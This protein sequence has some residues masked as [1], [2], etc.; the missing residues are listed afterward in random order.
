VKQGGLATQQADAVAE[1]I[2]A[3]AG[4]AVTPQPFRPIL[5]GML[6]TGE[7]PRYL[8][9]ELGATGGDQWDVSEHALC[10]RR[11]RSPVATCRHIS[12][13]GTPRSSAAQNMLGHFR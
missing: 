10:G 7:S 9:T 4:A 3:R 13:F 6:L 1:A 2:A 12:A 8:R 5:R 11:A